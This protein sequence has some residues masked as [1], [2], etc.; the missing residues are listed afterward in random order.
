MRYLNL[1]SVGLLCLYSLLGVLA[2]WVAYELRFDFNVP[3]EH[4][5]DRWQ[6]IGWVVALQVVLLL[7]AG[8]FDAILSYFRL[9]DALRLFLALFV[10]ALI[11]LLLWYLLA[12]RGVPPR[13]VILTN[14]LIVFLLLTGFRIAMRVQSSR[15]VEDWLAPDTAEHV[16]II[17]AGEVGAG[18]CADLIHKSRLGMRPVA[19]LDDDRRKI[20]RFIHG[21]LVA[22]GIDALEDVAH[23]FGASRAIIAFPSAST[24]RIRE[25]AELARS[26]GL[27]VD[28]V[29]ALT[30]LVSG[31]AELS[32]LRPIQLEDL[33]GREP[34]DLDSS[35]ISQMLA[36]KRVVITGA[37]GSIGRELVRQVLDHKPGALICLDQ[38][39]IAI[40][41]LQQDILSAPSA[42]GIASHT[43]VLDLQNE[44]SVQALFDQH[45]PEVI[46]HAAAHKHVPLMEA[47]PAEA[48][49]NNFCTTYQLALIASR[50]GCQRFILIS[51]DKA[52]NPTSVM[53][54][55]KRMAELALIV[56]Q[57]DPANTTR[58]MA[59]RFGNVL[60][61]SGS[62]IPIF[63]RQ[64]AQGGPLT[65]TDAEV[66]RFFMTVEEAVGL[67]LQSA[68][69]GEGGE[70]FVLDMGEPVK[71]MDIA[72]QMI[73]LS[74]LREGKDISIEVTGLRPGEKLYEEVQHVSESL[75][76]TQ[77]PRILRFVGPA[78]Q[79]GSLA[80]MHAAITE[81][82][83]HE[84]PA[85]LKA[86]ICHYVPEY[87]P[88]S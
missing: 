81:A 72:R 42:A 63:R 62:V 25:V 18:L 88:S 49:R 7:A 64:I 76:A 83:K 36:G 43:L 66:T 35:D 74:G 21:V 44:E 73:A 9:P 29:P 45:R 32:Q 68:T 58:F 41:D 56:R 47:Q 77:H 87:T 15:G 5:A 84:G 11:L 57:A 60:G 80:D 6:S 26:A 20:G 39:E 48:L 61:S 69:Q 40:F 52:I 54:A 33:L 17:G 13:A 30:D 27:S 82:L 1:R 85:A 46:F 16:I 28:R 19:F 75:Q 86:R 14:F 12:G 67:V 37:G 55:S 78:D 22:D 71:I 79:A 8:Q 50:S 70:I 10:H 2:Y 53:G 34:V 38:A 3:I 24:K 59:V 65:V 51:T 31:R 4:A 23:R